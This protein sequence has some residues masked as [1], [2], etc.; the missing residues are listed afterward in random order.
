MLEDGAILGGEQSGHLIFR[1]RATTGDG[2]LTAVRFLS[3]ASAAGRSVADL[4][5]VMRRY[6]QVTVNVRVVSI[7]ALDGARPVWDA[8]ARAEEELDG[9]GRVLVRASGTE[10]VVRVMVEA[11]TEDVARRHAD[12][13]AT[14]VREHLGA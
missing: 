4:A 1:D 5:G 6:P 8:V 11:E 14:T 3:L 12:S 2:I 7:A 10:P 9:T 13:V